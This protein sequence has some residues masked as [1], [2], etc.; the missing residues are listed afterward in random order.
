M[1]SLYKNK[2]LR[3]LAATLVIPATVSALTVSSVGAAPTQPQQAATPQQPDSKSP[4]KAQTA[5]VPAVPK[6]PAIS[7]P[8]QD[9]TASATTPTVPTQTQM[10]SPRR[11]RWGNLQFIGPDTISD[12]AAAVAP[13]VV[14]ITANANANSGRGRNAVHVQND[15]NKKIR[16][17]Y[18][19]DTPPPGDNDYLKVTG[20][21]IIINPNGYILTS[22]HVVESANN[23]TV[24]MQDGRTLDGTVTARDRFSDLALVKVNGSNLPTA[25]FGNADELRVG[26]WV[27][28]I[29]NQF[30]LGHTVTQGLISGLGRE[31]KGFEKS[32]GARTGAVRFIQTDAPINPG[33]SGGPLL[34]LRGEVIGINTFIRDDAQN[35]GFAI[36]AN[37]ARDV[38]DKLA[39][40]GA[41]AHPYIGIV[42]KEGPD[43]HSSTPGVE[44]AE[45]KFRSPA[46]SAGISPGDVIMQIDQSPVFSPDD[47]SVAVGKRRIG[48]SLK[49]KIRHENADK[50]VDVKIDR[51][52]E[53]GE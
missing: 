1:T 16:R 38:A 23:V 14:N 42:M 39:N 30:G 53:E 8:P 12:I 15:A 41:I 32:F 13:S 22:L 43:G 31:A 28:A 34:N 49:L 6:T 2:S 11:S 18:G 26:D 52:P 10:A 20:S 51:L 25:R 47:V 9:T 37:I 4:V 40:A 24:T 50:D 29:G 36:P 44:V 45:V 3:F 27:I 17:Y 35:I 46:S 33:S 21:G 19:M 7:V 48:E 5:V